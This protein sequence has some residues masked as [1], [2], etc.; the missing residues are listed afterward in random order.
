MLFP[1]VFFL[2]R[3]VTDPV[4]LG[5]MPHVDYLRAASAEGVEMVMCL[6]MRGA[7]DDVVDGSTLPSRAVVDHGGRAHYFP[8]QGSVTG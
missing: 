4:G 6:I 8:E 5:R 2:D 1:A 7:L 3:I